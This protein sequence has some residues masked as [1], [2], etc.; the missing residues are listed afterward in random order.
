V[1]CE[2]DCSQLMRREERWPCR[3]ASPVTPAGKRHPKVV[4][5][6]VACHRSP[7]QF[8]ACGAAVGIADTS[9]S[10]LVEGPFPQRRPMLDAALGCSHR[11]A[12]PA[13]GWAGER[14]DG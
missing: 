12:N 11:A 4:P 9:V 10:A 1:T 8:R 6:P 2:R 13:G 3:A 5:S 14:S 7:C